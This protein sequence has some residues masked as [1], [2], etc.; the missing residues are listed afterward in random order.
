MILAFTPQKNVCLSLPLIIEQEGIIMEEAFAREEGQGLVEYALVLVLVA[1]VVIAILL[2]LG[3]VV[4]N[5]F[6]NVVIA[7][8]KESGMPSPITHLSTGRYGMAGNDVWVTV[9]VSES[10]SVTA[11]DSQSGHYTTFTCG[12]T[13]SGVILAVGE[14]AGTVTVMAG[15]YSA[16]ASYPAK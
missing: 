6:S 5:V 15:G 10:M 9:T 11:T 3:P 14:N 12:G 2:L 16:S 1:T 13:C 7:L 8:Q 4:G